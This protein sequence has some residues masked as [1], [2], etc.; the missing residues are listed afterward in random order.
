M[1][2][3]PLVLEGAEEVD[4]LPA[5]GGE[6]LGWEGGDGAGDAVEAFFQ[7]LAEGPAG[8]VAGEHVEVVDVDGAVA[9]GFSGG[10]AVDVTEPVVGDDLAGGVEHHAAQGVVLVCVGINTPVAAVEVFINSG[11]D[12]DDGPGGGISVRHDGSLAS[13]RDSIF[14]MLLFVSNDV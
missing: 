14:F 6:V 13:F 3:G 8:A 11:G 12:V 10:G 7:E 9:V 4:D 1:C 5:G 2:A